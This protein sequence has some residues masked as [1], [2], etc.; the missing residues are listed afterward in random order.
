MAEAVPSLQHAGKSVLAARALSNALTPR[1]QD[2]KP[3]RG[4]VYCLYSRASE[5]W[6]VRVGFV[7]RAWYLFSVPFHLTFWALTDTSTQTVYLSTEY[8]IDALLVAELALLAMLAMGSD[9]TV[10][11]DNAQVDASLPATKEWLWELAARCPIDLML[12]VGGNVSLIP[13]LRLSRLL[14]VRAIWME[15][16]YAELDVDLDYLAVRLSTMI[17]CLVL[18]IHWFAC[19][20]FLLARFR[21]LGNGT[22]ADTLASESTHMRYVTSLYWVLSCISGLAN[23]TVPITFGEYVYTACV[24]FALFCAVVYVTGHATSLIVQRDAERA[25]FH[26]QA[27]LVDDFSRRRSIPDSLCNQMRQHH[28]LSYLTD[29]E[30]DEQFM[31]RFPQALRAEV[32]RLLYMDHLRSNVLLGAW[33]IA[34]VSPERGTAFLHALAEE[35][36]VRVLVRECPV[37]RR[38]D[39]ARELYLLVHGKLKLM[40]WPST[41]NHRQR[42]RPRRSGLVFRAGSTHSRRDRRGG[43][44]PPLRVARALRGSGTPLP[45]RTR[46]HMQRGPPALVFTRK[47]LARGQDARRRGTTKGP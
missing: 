44:H 20:L 9:S 26:E 3:R 22:W 12:F 29:V 47:R 11:P 36:R 41:H 24:G 23:E 28:I 32:A 8:T 10:Y 27:R 19:A 18:M 33:R 5:N 25:R 46:R 2:S 15:V 30:R 6:I 13:I 45:G 35:M 21:G 17:S 34:G 39:V 7:C 4:G 40:R 14:H 1:P 31:R 42:R 37:F 43:L 16:S 38:N